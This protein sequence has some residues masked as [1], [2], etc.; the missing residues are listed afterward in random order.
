MPQAS[1]HASM[2][3][4]HFTVWLCNWRQYEILSH[5][6]FYL[7]R[8]FSYLGASMKYSE[9]KN[10]KSFCQSLHSEPNWREVLEQA[11]SGNDDF[12]VDNVR[13]IADEAIDDIQADEMES[14]PYILGCFNAYAIAQATDWP[15]ALIEAAQKGEAYSEIG[16]AMSREQVEKLQQIYSS[17]DGYGNHFNG[18]D[19]G[20]E[21]IE[22]DG[23][24]FHVFDN[25]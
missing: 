5:S 11:L 1:T 20:E 13:F 8:Y 23:K 24:L 9:L 21:E 14:D 2:A 6:V 22:I 12:E 18:Y 10:L 25:R 16:D 3:C 19:F 7:G 4:I 15:V 17:A